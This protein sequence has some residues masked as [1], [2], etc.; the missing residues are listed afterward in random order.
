MPKRRANREGGITWLSRSKVLLRVSVDGRQRSKTVKV[1]DKE[2]GGRGEADA[3]LKEFREE[4]E[5]EKNAPPKSSWTLRT[6][7]EDY[8][9]SRAGSARPDQPSSPTASSPGGSPTS[10]GRFPSMS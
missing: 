3:A 4:L 10:W 1:A 2:H 6:L 7:L 5:S 9:E 8:A